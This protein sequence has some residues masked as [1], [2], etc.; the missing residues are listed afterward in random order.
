MDHNLSLILSIFFLFCGILLCVKNYYSL[1]NRIAFFILVLISLIL[2]LL[3]GVSDYF[4]G[5]GINESVIYH[6]KYG[7]AGAGFSEYLGLIIVSSIILFLGLFF[8][9]YMFSRKTK[10]K[11]LSVINK[12]IYFSYLLIFISLVVN[13]AVHDLFSLAFN[14]SN[15][16]NF[17][18]YYLKPAI[19]KLN[20]NQKN[21]IVIYAESLE[22]TY[23]DE[24]TFPGLIKELRKLESKSTYFTNIVEIECTG[25][26][27]AGIVASQCGIPLITPLYR[28]NS[29]S[30]MDSYLPSAVGLSDLLQNEGY[31]FIYYGGANLDFAGKR[32]FFS[33]H[34]YDEVFGKKEL[35][36]LLTDKSYMTSWGLFDDTLLDIVFDKFI[37]LS[38]RDE[39]FCLFLLTL[40]T[41]NPKGDPSKKCRDIIYGDGLNPILNA[42]AGSDYLISDFINKILLSSFAQKT[43][44]VVLSDHL[45][46]NN[47]AY[48]LLKPKKR[49]NMFMI[50][51]PENLSSRKIQQLGSTLDI[52]ATILPFIGYECSLGLGRNLLSKKLWD[53]DIE[54][55]QKNITGWKQNLSKFWN[56]PNIHESITINITENYLK[57]DERK[58]RIPILIEFNNDFET[59]L[60]FTFDGDYRQS[61]LIDYLKTL[62]KNKNFILIDKCINVGE[63][64]KDVS[65]N[66]F[67]IIIG[68]GNEYLKKMKLSENITLNVNEL[69]EILQL[70][71]VFRTRRIAHA[72]GGIDNVTYTNSFQALNHNLKRGFLYFEL[73]FSYTQDKQLVCVHDFKKEF[74]KLTGIELKERP[75]LEVLQSIVNN[76]SKFSLCTVDT[77]AMW[78]QQN[79]SA[80]IITDVKEEDNI[81]VLETI[82]TKLP[83]FEDRVIPQIY[84]PEDYSKAKQLGYKQII[85]TLYRYAGTNEDVLKWVDKFN[86]PFAITM[87]KERAK[88]DLPSKLAEKRIPSYVHTVNTKEEADNFLKKYKITDIYTDFLP[89][90]D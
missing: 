68:R 17:D 66:D 45:T 70:K 54:C 88:T 8:L 47:T 33:T 14:K 74:K 4:T 38:E 28:G 37:K 2:Y 61:R 75:T 36:G 32:K 43:I 35:S 60:T 84:Y 12:N 3:Y 19:K 15:S 57:I 22:R 85:W 56:F 59:I 34:H 50:I 16:P 42:V 51:D 90:K 58:F 69:R 30:G 83:N 44:I 46:M 82:A 63:I 81:K 72:G 9:F 62:D 23:F 1:K 24:S 77:L 55:I 40:D 27:I 41:H 13:P 7:F 5:K 67:C 78:M 20:K 26:T 64:D 53:S 52:G 48:H 29:M 79:P 65:Q 11:S 21:L 89:E 6:I 71:S 86:G 18:I 39:K 10:I 87:P 49:T 25:W 73:D 76:Y 80:I 31:K